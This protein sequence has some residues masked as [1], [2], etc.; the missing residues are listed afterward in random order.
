M[1]NLPQIVTLA[2]LLPSVGAFI[3]LFWGK[4]MGERAVGLLASG[5]AGGAFIVSFLLFLSLGA[6]HGEAVVVNPPLLDGWIRLD[7]VGVDFPWQQRVDTLSVA[8]ML[9]VTGVGTLIHIY[10]V[11]YMHGDER[12]ARFFSY[13]NMFL[14]FMLVLVTGNNFLM[15]FVGWEGVGLCSYLLI[16]FWWDKA[17]GV[18][19]RNSN[20]ARKAMIAN[21]IGDAGLIMGLLLTFWTFGTL[22]YFKPGEVVNPALAAELHAEDAEHS[23]AAVTEGDHAEGEGA[24]VAEEGHGEEAAAEGDHAEGAV[25]EEGHG[26]EAAHGETAAAAPINNDGLA[27]NQLGVFGQA[28]RLLHLPEG[29]P[30]R[31]ITFGPFSLDIDTVVVVITLTRQRFNSR[32]DNGYGGRLYDGALQRVIS[33]SG[34]YLIYC[35]GYWRNNSDHGGFHRAWAVGH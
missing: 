8:M 14:A 20:A 26:E 13:L 23:E 21:R 33:R 32:R 1:E 9:V 5:M 18:G 27:L 34:T 25:A 2:I 19:W 16:G 3:N 22:D 31:L 29:D 7:S 17:K 6:T 11:G 35:G 28:E 15:M 10:A 24:A 12:F 30:G 4:R